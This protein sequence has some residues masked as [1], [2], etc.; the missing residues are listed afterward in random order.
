MENIFK[1]KVWGSENW[2]VNNDKY[3]A[4]ILTLNKGAR[5]SFHYHNIKDETFIIMQGT[6]VLKTEEDIRVMVEGDK[7]RIFPGMKHYFL[8]IDDSRILEVSTQHFE[9]DSYRVDESKILSKEEFEEI[10]RQIVGGEL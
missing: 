4:K 6:V 10:N 7:V 9:Y 5:C 2:L 8:G 1:E 3:C